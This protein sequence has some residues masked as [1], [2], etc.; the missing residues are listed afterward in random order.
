MQTP[1]V[2]PLGVRQALEEHLHP[3]VAQRSDPW[4]ARACINRDRIVGVAFCNGEEV[5]ST[6]YFYLHGVQRP[7]ELHVMQLRRV[8]QVLPEY[9]RLSVAE[10]LSAWES[11]HA[12]VFEVV[13]TYTTH[14]SWTF[15][16]G[17]DIF[18]LTDLIFD[19]DWHIVGDSSAAFLTV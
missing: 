19:G 17:E 5:D 9:A 3:A 7:L 15:Q 6:T 14:L 10:R 13:G 1:S 12:H 8:P 18:V 2:P 16:P 4:V 11:Y